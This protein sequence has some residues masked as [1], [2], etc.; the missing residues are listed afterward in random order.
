MCNIILVFFLNFIPVLAM[1]LPSCKPAGSC[2]V[3]DELEND[4]NKLIP[5]IVQMLERTANTTSPFELFTYFT[6]PDALIH[7]QLQCGYLKTQDFIQFI[8]RTQKLKMASEYTKQAQLTSDKMALSEWFIDYF[9][10][11]I[12]PRVLQDLKKERCKNLALED[13]NL[14]L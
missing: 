6:R 1:E 4:Y 11:Q 3:E 8:L 2:P 10:T 9:K 12:A 5:Y 14:L 7:T 13:R